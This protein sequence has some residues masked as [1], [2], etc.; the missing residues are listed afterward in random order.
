[1]APFIGRFRKKD[2]MTLKRVKES[3]RSSRWLNWIVGLVLLGS[4]PFMFPTGRSLQFADMKEGSISTRRV[5]APFNFEILKTREEYQTDRDLAVRQVQ[6]VFRRGGNVLSEIMERSVLFFDDAYS[7]RMRIDENP[8][9]LYFYSDSLQKK[10]SLSI[11][12]RYINQILNPKG[13]VRKA[14]LMRF[15]N[16]IENLIRDLLGNG[17]LSLE[18]DEIDHPDRRIVVIEGNSEFSNMLENFDSVSDGWTECAKFLEETYANQDVF[19]H[20]GYSLIV[21]WLRPNLIYDEDLHQNRIEEAIAKV[22][23]S[24]GFVYEN[25]RIVGPNERIT[26]EIRKKLVS[27]STKMAEKGM[28]ESGIK[29]YLPFIG[30]FMFVAILLFIFTA[31]LYIEMP[32]ILQDFKM[33]LLLGILL[34]LISLLTFFTHRL[35]GSEFLVPAALGGMLLTT[36]FNPKV[37]YV[38]NAVVSVLVGALWGNEFSLMAVSFFSGVV[39]VLTIQRIRDRSQL[40]KVIFFL[41]GAYV[42]SITAMGLLRFMSFPEIIKQLPY[43]ALNGLFTPI[44]IFGLLPLIES[45]F[46]ITTDFSLLELSNLNHPL[47][48]R[49]SLEATGTYHHS[50]MV[51]NL[52]EAASQSINA[53]SLLAR[54]GSYYHDIGKLEKAEYFVENQMGGE[55]PHEKL[56][57]RM[58]ALIL[59]NHV[60]R[61]L[62]LAEQNKLP[63]S[64]KDIIVEHQGTTVMP[65]F[66]RKAIEKAGEEGVNDDDYRYG[67]PKPRTKESAIVMLADVVEAATR[68]LKAPTHSRLKGLVNDLI[69]ER[70]QEGELSEAPLTLRD[71]E[72]IKESFLMILGGIF[73]TRV[74]YPEKEDTKKDVQETKQEE[75]SENSENKKISNS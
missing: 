38:G 54:V 15:Q 58:S 18:K 11:E 67:G 19:K 24:S 39:G 69:E 53:N 31:F 40:I 6:P 41:A 28:Q 73:H 5:V 51:G 65:F 66:Y 37:G 71:L 17:I 21:S 43:G 14:H 29:R 33:I 20:V 16:N 10:F 45:I 26:P 74:E 3:N 59:M 42:I 68:S 9:L 13:P 72:R 8:D 1:M 30:K 7:I 49:L 56:V 57:P 36:L 63:K 32:E 46:D 27:L 64:I 60:K 22:P 35:E 61:G 55:N 75:I 12:S 50:I 70:F 52:A 34:A 47:L 4:I 25:E 62:E 2:V 44:V 48:K 23:L